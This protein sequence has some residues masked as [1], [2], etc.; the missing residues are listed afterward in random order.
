MNS[1][2]SVFRNLSLLFFAACA[3]HGSAPSPGPDAAVAL[4]PSCVGDA[5]ATGLGAYSSTLIAQ[6]QAADL[7]FRATVTAVHA[8][9][10]PDPVDTT[11]LV[12][13]QVTATA[14]ASQGIAEL[15]STWGNTLTIDLASANL[16]V[17]ATVFFLAQV[18]TYN[19]GQLEVKEITRV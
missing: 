12:V 10:I 3:S 11:S 17:G 1:S 14:Y 2:R 8:K 16:A 18:E 9:T 5:P 15:G 6:M 13:A 7:I 19:G 4:G